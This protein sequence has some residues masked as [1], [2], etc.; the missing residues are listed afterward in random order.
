MPWSETV[1]WLNDT[2]S[3]FNI[4]EFKL[5]SSLYDKLGKNNCPNSDFGSC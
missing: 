3:F 2:T 1:H 4:M 5:A